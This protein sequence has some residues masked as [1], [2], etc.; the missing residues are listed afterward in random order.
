VSADTVPVNIRILDKEY[1]VGCPA[2]ERDELIASARYLDAKMREIRDSRKV[3]GNDRIAVIC[4]LNI[5]HELL[6][7]KNQ[8]SSTPDAFVE[9]V[10][11]LGD[12]IESSLQKSSQLDLS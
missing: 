12:K 9:R 1:C 6:Q 7:K 10:K 11:R 4:A 5:A 8:K 2:A 3:T